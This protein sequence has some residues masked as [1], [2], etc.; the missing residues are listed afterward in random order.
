[1]AKMTVSV[2]NALDDIKLE[3]ASKMKRKKEDKKVKKEKK[4]S[5][6]KKGYLSQVRSEMKKVTWPSKKNLVKYSFAT[7]VMIVLLA[8][9]FIGVTALFDLLYSLV[10]G[11]L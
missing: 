11:W 4:E 7:I 8:L 2:D 6:N 5:G 3:S 10:Q 9:F 1:M